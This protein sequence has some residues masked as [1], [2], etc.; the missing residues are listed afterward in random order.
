MFRQFWLDNVAQVVGTAGG[1]LANAA[2]VKI[3]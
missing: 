1:F 2:N 3:S